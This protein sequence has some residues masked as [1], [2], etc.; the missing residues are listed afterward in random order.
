M[1]WGGSLKA[2]PDK[3]Y[4]E[5]KAYKTQRDKER[6]DIAKKYFVVGYL[7]GIIVS[8]IIMWLI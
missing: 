5:V 3:I 1:G 7:L 4:H 2:K 8:L 6:R